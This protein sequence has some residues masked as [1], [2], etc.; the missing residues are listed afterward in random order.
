MRSIVNSAFNWYYKMRY[1]E[2]ERILNHPHESQRE[3]FDNLIHSARNTEYGKKYGFSSINSPKDF[4]KQVPV[5]DYERL[6]PYIQRMMDGE[7]NILWPGRVEMFS[8][9]SGTTSAK[10][11]FIPVSQQNFDECH[12]KGGWDTMTVI[13]NQ[14]PDCT[15]FSGTTSDPLN[16]NRP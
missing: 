5:S 14:M 3:V 16:T 15:I 10:S 13:Y 12:I 11:K 9:S 8:K 2:I 7:K 4:R 1:R 6:K